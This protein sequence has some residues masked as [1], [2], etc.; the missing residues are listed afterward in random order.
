M[1]NWALQVT[2]MKG[3]PVTGKVP[4][5]IFSVKVPNSPIGRLWC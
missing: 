5:E 1:D 4:L 3:G 2:S